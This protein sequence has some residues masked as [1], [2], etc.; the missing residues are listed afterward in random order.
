MPYVKIILLCIIVV[1]RL[2][3]MTLRAAVFVVSLVTELWN[4]AAITRR[5]PCDPMQ[6]NITAESVLKNVVLSVLKDY[7]VAPIWFNKPMKYVN[8]SRRGLN[9][10]PQRTPSNVQI[11]DLS[12]NVIAEIRK[13]DLDKF[14]ELQVLWLYSN[15]IGN[16]QHT[17]F[18]C[19]G[20][21]LYEQNA[22]SS[23]VNL[24]VLNVGGNA[25]QR[26]PTNL[27]PTLEYLDVSR[28]GLTRIRHSD[29]HYLKNLLIFSA[30]NLCFSGHCDQFEFD[31]HVFTDLPLSVI[32]LSE[33]SNVFH[34]LLYLNSISLIYV[35][36]VQTNVFSLDPEH[37]RH[38]TSVKRLDLYQLHRNEHLKLTIADKTFDELHA[39]EYLDLSSNE[40]EYI[41]NNIFQYNYNLVYLDLSG[42]CLQYSVIDPKFA[43]VQIKFLYL[44]YN[45][46][47]F[48][49]SYDST[50][51]TSLNALN[52]QGAI[53]LGES[54]LKLK[55]LTVL[56]YDKPQHV[57]RS[58]PNK[59]PDPFHY[60]TNTTVKNLMSLEN[61]KEFIT[62]NNYL[63]Q[64]D[65]KIVSCMRALQNID[66]SRNIINNLTVSG[67]PC[68]LQ[69]SKVAFLQSDVIYCPLTIKLSLSYN[70]VGMTLSNDFLVHPMATTLD[71]SFN[72]I[73]SIRRKAFIHMPCLVDIDLR[74][75]PIVYLHMESFNN[76]RSLMRLFLT[77]TGFV[78]NKDSFLFF[79]KIMTPLSLR[80]SLLKDNLFNILLLIY[81]ETGSAVIQDVD[82]SDNVIPSVKH[83]QNG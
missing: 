9:K 70:K 76:L 34:A 27:P 42:N 43:P 58:S 51:S 45:R 3:N 37:M 13:K 4:V 33:N 75:N 57:D 6:S 7:H 19:R 40:I 31:S 66:L 24:K 56:S 50:F 64:I 18:Y 47:N 77:S 12:S 36:F 48:R 59:S 82:L 8:C 71:L 80:L 73:S 81:R 62:T 52:V 30:K 25:F 53:V 65:L 49:D 28:T 67:Q 60:I 44:G 22:F 63:L 26:F 20:V 74:N 78:K 69:R 72:L 1:Y 38:I 10:I 2:V 79:K 32:D 29:L 39:L 41:P 11:L 35:N 68:G 5:D 17:H 55:N 23:L 14:V 16:S 83:I 21:G 61:L 46:C 54:F 15:C